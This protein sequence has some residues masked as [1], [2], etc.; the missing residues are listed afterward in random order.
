MLKGLKTF[1]LLVLTL[2]MLTTISYSERLA[3]KDVEPVVYNGVKYSALHWG[4]KH[5]LGQN[6]GVIEASNVKS[7]KRLWLLKVYTIH[8][9]KDLETDVQ[10][11]FITT[12]KIENG[13]LIVTNE[14]N[15][16]Y[17]VSLSTKKITPLD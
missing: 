16:K 14:K 1:Y 13:D 15:K 9:I 8:Y 10:D 17:K 4:Y 2:I 6:G 11:I 5:G 3:P 7:G 12:L